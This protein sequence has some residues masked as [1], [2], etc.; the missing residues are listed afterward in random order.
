MFD[1]AELHCHT[2][3]SFLDG[4]S[5]AEDL[6]ARAVELSYRALAV[7]DHNGFYGAVRFSTA[8]RDAGLPAV[9]GTEIGL[10][11][12]WKPP[13]VRPKPPPIQPGI[14]RRGR[15]KRMHGQKPTNKEPTD[16]LLLLA[17]S[18]AGYRALSRFV[19]NAQFRG[20]KDRPIYLQSDLEDLAKVADL[21]VLSGCR[22]G[23]I[24]EAANRGDLA[25]TMSAAIGLREVFGDRFYLEMWHHGM[26]E[27]DPRNDLIWEVA[28][29]LN[30]GVVA[31]NNVHYHRREDADLSEVLAAVGGRRSL[32]TADGFR[33]ATDERYL[34]SP[35]E[36]HRRFERYPGAIRNALA[37]A[38]E[39]TFDLRLVAPRLPD[40]P[41]PGH[42]RSEM[43]YLRSLTWEGAR[44]VYPGNGEGLVDPMAA[45]PART[46]ARHH[47]QARIRW[48]FPR[49]LGHRRLRP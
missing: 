18:P 30:L 6:V 46:R 27:D 15:N 24:G 47:R 31:T 22:Q 38:E 32:E 2:N 23:V 35:A 36:M 10:S 16:H 3:F 25:A 44:D 1:Y 14:R 5:H 19:T 37:L 8:A 34:K 9:Y 48:L 20:E 29:R 11:R 45:D 40:F 43:E 13:A 49:G 17:G 12:N 33:P 41:M 26:P 7:T 4:A 39:L 42:F 28:G 21:A